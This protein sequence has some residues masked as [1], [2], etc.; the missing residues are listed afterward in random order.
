MSTQARPALWWFNPEAQ[1]FFNSLALDQLL[2]LSGDLDKQ[3]LGQ[4]SDPP[5]PLTRAK[6]RLL[7]RV[8][9]SEGPAYFVKIQVAHPGLIRL[10]KWPSYALKPSP[11]IRE[12]RAAELLSNLG[13][14]TPQ[15]L[16]SGAT[17]RFPRTMRAA[18]ITR[19][20]PAY[21]DL[22]QVPTST[23]IAAVEA[24]IA[25]VHA[26][27]YALGGARFR[28]F[29]VPRAGAQGPHEVVIIDAVNFGRG[30]RKRA[31][32]RSQFDFDRARLG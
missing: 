31:R 11:L 23:N 21:T 27:G 14:R 5:G 28:D 17:G 24:V 2:D 1:A 9:A 20:V 25:Q 22:A 30:R 32:D 3:R 6:T 19:E 8:P 16:A 12:A 13:L 4:I 15:I 10:K 18:L 29:L 26:K 7:F